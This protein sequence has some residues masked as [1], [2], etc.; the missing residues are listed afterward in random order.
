MHRDM[1]A[2]EINPTSS[3][4]QMMHEVCAKFWELG[5]RSLPACMITIEVSATKN[6]LDSRS[7]LLTCC[8]RE[9]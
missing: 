2:L 7:A 5:A 4:D 1:A 8:F 3:A 9:W 6:K